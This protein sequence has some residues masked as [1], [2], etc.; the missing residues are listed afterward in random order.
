MQKTKIQNVICNIVELE[1]RRIAINSEMQKPETKKKKKRENIACKMQN[2]YRE[3]RKYE[4]QKSKM[5]NVE[6]ENAEIKLQKPKNSKQ[7]VEN[8]E[9]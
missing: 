1:K 5:Q 9:T 8:V 6:T 3:T 2:H 4:I 7:N